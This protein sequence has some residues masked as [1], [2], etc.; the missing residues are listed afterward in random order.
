M[1]ENPKWFSAIFNDKIDN[2]AS[3]DEEEKHTIFVTNYRIQT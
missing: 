3:C 2:T 1:A